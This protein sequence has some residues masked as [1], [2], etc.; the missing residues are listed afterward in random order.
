MA[1]TLLTFRSAWNLRS[2]TG[3]IPGECLI[4]STWTNLIRVFQS[5]IVDDGWGVWVGVTGHSLH[6]HL[7]TQVSPKVLLEFA[8]DF[9]IWSFQCLHSSDT[10]KICGNMG[11]L[12]SF[13]H[14]FCL[15]WEL[16]RNLSCPDNILIINLQDY[17]HGFFC[18]PLILWWFWVISYF[19][20]PN[21]WIIYLTG[22][23]QG[24]QMIYIEAYIALWLSSTQNT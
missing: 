13:P 19:T 8:E 17:F 14:W 6:P 22:Y 21:K 2:M 23:I 7:Q 3:V 18:W 16:S 9:R 1:F 5:Q 15:I 20:F 12:G 11:N 4:N 24:Q 10:E